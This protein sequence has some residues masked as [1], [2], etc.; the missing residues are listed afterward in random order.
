MTRLVPCPECTRHVVFGE[1]RCP[2]CSA[3][4]PARPAPLPAIPRALALRSIPRAGISK[5]AA[6]VLA[7][8]MSG[9]SVACGV[10]FD[11]PDR[12]SMQVDVYGA[13]PDTGVPRDTGVRDVTIVDVYG[14]PPDA[15][16]DED[17][18]EDDAGGDQ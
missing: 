18:G 1:S 7:A 9:G 5:A 3:T 2:F 14:A 15:G 10:D 12:G 13:P 11:G 6:T 17:A 8:A 4:L 16:V